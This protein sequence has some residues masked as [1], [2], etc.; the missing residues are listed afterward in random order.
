MPFKDPEAMKARDKAYYEKNKEKQKAYSK[1]YYE[2]NKEKKKAYQQTPKG[3]KTKR[4]SC[5]KRRGVI[6]DDWD[7]LYEHFINTSFCE[8]CE[9]ALTE[10]KVTTP[11]TRCLDHCHET[12]LFRNVLCNTCNLLRRG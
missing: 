7:A 11:T 8:N 9:V 2:K 12:H 5:W 1:A 4:I 10:D 6:C 3:K